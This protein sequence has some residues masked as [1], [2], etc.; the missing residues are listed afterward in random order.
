LIKLNTQILSPFYRI[1]SYRPQ[2]AGV[3]N[4]KQNNW[5]EHQV[6]QST[7]QNTAPCLA[8]ESEARDGRD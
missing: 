4:G 1:M 8:S 2:V 5:E 6:N 3:T 7:N